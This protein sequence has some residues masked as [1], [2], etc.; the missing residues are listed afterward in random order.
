[1]EAVMWWDHWWNDYWPMPFMFL[2]PVVMLLFIVICISMM[3]MMMRGGK[4][5]R[6]GY[7]L[8]ILKERFARGE[9]NQTEYEE[10]RRTLE[11]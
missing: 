8:E 3:W 5:R 11:A 2:G 1:M 10:R 4:H 9:I 6:S 7:A